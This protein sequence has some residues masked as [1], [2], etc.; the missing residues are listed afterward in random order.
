MGAVRCSTQARTAARRSG[1]W[2]TRCRNPRVQCSGE[3]RVQAAA[4]VAGDP[5]AGGVDVFAG[6]E[7]VDGS[8]AVPD[9]PA[10]DGFPE[11][12][13]GVT[14]LVMHVPHDHAF[15]LGDGVVGE[16]NNPPLRQT[17]ATRLDVRGGPGGG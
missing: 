14:R 7:V 5:N 17:E 1:S 8:H 12:Q 16:N 6:L 10:S 13:Q 4:R 15:S 3:E 2:G 9:H 11:R